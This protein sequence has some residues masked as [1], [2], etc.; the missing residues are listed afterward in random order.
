[1]RRAAPIAQARPGKLRTSAA[2]SPV[3]IIS[4]VTEF[5][6]NPARRKTRVTYGE[7]RRMYRRP[8]Q[9][10]A[11]ARPTSH[12]GWVAALSSA[13]EG[14]DKVLHAGSDRCLVQ[15]EVLEDG[16]TI[17]AGRGGESDGSG[18]LLLRESKVA[19]QA[20]DAVAAQR[21]FQEFEDAV[22]AQE[23]REQRADRNLLTVGRGVRK[24][25]VDCMRDLVARAAARTARARRGHG[26]AAQHERLGQRP[27]EVIG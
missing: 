19:R 5:A 22:A 25:R 24:E 12:S 8:A 20:R 14:A 11:S 7:T 26:E 3:G 10:S 15:F 2:R 13:I 17:G 16:E 6:L 9:C 1:M 4:A 23:G 21:R 18:E 27:Q